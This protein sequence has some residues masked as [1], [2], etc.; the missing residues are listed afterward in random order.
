MMEDEMSLIPGRGTK[1]PQVAQYS[2]K[3]R[4]QSDGKKSKQENILNQT[5]RKL[6]NKTEWQMNIQIN[7]KMSTFKN[8]RCFISTSTGVTF[9]IL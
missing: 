7:V 4:Q 9:P 2:Q 3:K 5:T 6:A 1:L 8:V